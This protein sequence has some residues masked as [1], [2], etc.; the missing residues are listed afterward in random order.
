MSKL[1]RLLTWLSPAFPVG[2]FSYSH[3][4]EQAVEAGLVTSLATTIDWIATIVTDGAGRADAALLLEAHRAADDPDRLDATAA[5]AD[6]LR[7]TAEL[8]LEASGQG[9]AFLATVAAAWPDPWADAWKAR[10]K[11]Q[12]RGLA[13][14]VAVGAVTARAGIAEAEALAAYLQAF[15]ANLVS[16]AVRLVP[17]GQT[18][19]QRALAALEPVILAAAEAALARPFADLGSAAPMVDWCSM[20]HETQYTR[21]FRS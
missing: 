18:D 15:A 4:L 5:L 19:G 2:G 9:N 21:L 20:T 13:Y 6:V 7:P 16:A 14:P 8:A 3:G 12:G 10:L 17:L 1:V 11:R